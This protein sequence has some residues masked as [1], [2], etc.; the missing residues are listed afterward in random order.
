MTYLLRD[1]PDGLWNRVKDRAAKEGHTV[2][3]IVIELL[4]RYVAQG[5]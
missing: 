1:V 4:R 3:Y 2:K 5:L